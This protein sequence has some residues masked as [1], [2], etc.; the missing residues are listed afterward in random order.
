[1]TYAGSGLGLLPDEEIDLSER[2]IR[3]EEDN[4][5]SLTDPVTGLADATL[6]ARVA[7][8]SGDRNPFLPIVSAAEMH[9]LIAEH[10]LATGDTAGFTRHI[11]A[12]RAIHGRAP[13]GGAVPAMD[14]LQ[15]ERRVHLFLQGR[16]LL[17]HYRFGSVGD[18]WDAGSEAATSPGTFLPIPESERVANPF[19]R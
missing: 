12:A 8:V 14:L 11:D 16:R 6:A 2:L 19:V 13:S 17:D 1:M 15:H 18:G 10:A 5:K 3:N 7:E 4:G 9:L